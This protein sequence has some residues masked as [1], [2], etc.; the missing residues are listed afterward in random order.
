MTRAPRRG[1]DDRTGAEK[2]QSFLAGLIPWLLLASFL[3]LMWPVRFGGSTD[4][5]IVSGHSMERTYHTGDLV[6]TKERPSYGV[7]DVVVYRIP[8]EGA[9]AGREIVHRLRERLPDGRFLV[10]GD[11]NRTDDP[12]AITTD[13]IVGAKWLMVA[14]GGIFLGFLRSILMVAVLFGVLV[15]WVFWPR[16]DVPDEHD[17]P[18]TAAVAPVLEPHWLDDEAII[19][20]WN[21]LISSGANVPTE[22]PVPRPV[23]HWLDDDGVP[24]VW[25]AAQ[26]EDSVASRSSV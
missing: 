17:A 16:D 4:F 21:T 12:W 7:G 15:A 5:I 24:D 10:R 8:G 6:I 26:D 3:A 22:L 23:L 9:G 13:Q 18:T 14:K 2:F 11:N 1:V 25:L 20:D 19:D